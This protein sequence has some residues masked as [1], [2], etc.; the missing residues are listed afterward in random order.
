MFDKLPKTLSMSEPWG[1][2]YLHELRRQ[3]KITH[4]KYLQL[5]RSCVILQF[6]PPIQKETERLDFISVINIYLGSKVLTPSWLLS[7][8]EQKQ[9]KVLL[10][11][12]NFLGVSTLSSP[13][14]E[15]FVHFFSYVEWY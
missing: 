4:S 3:N 2:H 12:I 13:F 11:W 9:N 8:R 6:K 14:S 5:L 10:V 15:K 1:L 7:R